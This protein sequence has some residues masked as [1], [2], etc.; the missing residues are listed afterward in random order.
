MGSLSVQYIYIY[1]SSSFHNCNKHR[2]M[3]PSSSM[4][5]RPKVKS[6]WTRVPWSYQCLGWSYLPA[7]FLTT[8]MGHKQPSILYLLPRY[9]WG[10]GRRYFYCMRQP[11][12]SVFPNLC[13]KARKAGIWWNGTSTPG[14]SYQ[15]AA[16]RSAQCQLDSGWKADVENRDR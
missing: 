2:H 9:S 3:Q 12:S 6:C 10:A 1:I 11:N 4:L 7:A 8:D 16:E 13:H 15:N 14:K 5:P